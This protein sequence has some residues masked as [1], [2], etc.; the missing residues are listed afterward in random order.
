MNT[1]YLMDSCSERWGRPWYFITEE[2]AQIPIKSSSFDYLDYVAILGE[3]RY[4]IGITGGATNRWAVGRIQN[5]YFEV[6]DEVET[7][8]NLVQS[9][10]HVAL[11]TLGEI[12]FLRGI[13]Q[14][15]DIEIVNPRN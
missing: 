11:S 12:G 9:G 8:H 3:N 4:L 15:H 14:K 1:N 13:S 6:E 10:P 5:Q 2:R 7:Q